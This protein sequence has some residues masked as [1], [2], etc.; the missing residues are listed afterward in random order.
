MYP[1]LPRGN[2]EYDPTT[3][4]ALTFIFDTTKMNKILG[5][6]LKTMEETTKDVLEDF[7]QRG[8]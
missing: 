5:I 7:K 6:K 8:W 4:A 3:K 2:M 1:D